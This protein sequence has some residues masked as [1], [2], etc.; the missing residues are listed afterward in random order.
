MKPVTSRDHFQIEL[1]V[2]A[3]MLKVRLQTC[4]SNG[5]GLRAILV[6]HLSQ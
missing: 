6:A 4:N 2:K 5:S 3:L 1:H